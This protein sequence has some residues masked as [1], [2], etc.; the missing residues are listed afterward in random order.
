MCVWSVIGRC[1][2]VKPRT[3]ATV[4]SRSGREWKSRECGGG[5]P[6]VPEVLAGPGHAAEAHAGPGVAQGSGT[7][8][9]DGR[10]ESHLPLCP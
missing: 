7:G 4:G 1:A 3:A 6:A 5:V 9:H 10:F 2:A 8:A